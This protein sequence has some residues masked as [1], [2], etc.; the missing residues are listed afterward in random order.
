M[1]I[2]EFQAFRIMLHGTWV[3]PKNSEEQNQESGS[4]PTAALFHQKKMFAL[5][6]LPH[7]FG[8]LIRG[9]NS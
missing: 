8:S 1:F 6:E 4:S 5:Y 3:L 7:S 2:D 9:N